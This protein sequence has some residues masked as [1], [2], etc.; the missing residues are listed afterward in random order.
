ML[1]VKAT[2]TKSGSASLGFINLFDAK[3]YEAKKDYEQLVTGGP[4]TTP[5]FRPSNWSFSKGK[6]TQYNW[7]KF[8]VSY[9]PKDKLLN[10]DVKVRFQFI[11]DLPVPG[12]TKDMAE[13]REKRHQAYQASFEQQVVAG[14]SGKFQLQNIREPQS[15]WGK[16]NPVNVKVNVV[17]VTTAKAGAPPAPTHWTIKVKLKSLGTAEVIDSQSL[18]KFYKGD[19]VPQA[20]FNPQ[21]AK[22]EIKRLRPIIPTPIVFGANSTTVDPKYNARLSF[23][24]DY[25]KRL[26][27]PQF[28]LDIVGHANKVGDPA[29]NQTLSAERATNVSGALSG[30]GL[31]NHILSAKGVGDTGASASTRWRKVDITADM[32]KV[33]WQNIQDVTLHEFGHMIGLDDE[34]DRGDKRKLA[35]HYKLIEMAFG[36][37]YAKQ[38]SKI[39]GSSSASIMHG[40][41]DVRIHHYVTFWE[42]LYQITEA[43]AIPKKE[44]LGQKDWKFVE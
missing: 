14:W 33:G 16:L 17:D 13:K 44:P 15:V 26:N 24:A 28:K 12:E 37:K 4:Y 9:S 29:K 19:D 2:E 1:F 32:A 27:N 7:G 21:T 10:A 22:D 43:A 35:E 31:N 25:L 39:S 18:V 3:F 23:L 11:D 38:V 42:A 34:Y 30:A 5:N 36:E 41:N 6:F 20:A 8:D 40:G